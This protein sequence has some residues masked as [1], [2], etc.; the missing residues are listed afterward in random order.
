M[1]S[2]VSCFIEVNDMSKQEM[3]Y[4]QNLQ[5][6]LQLIENAGFASI[7]EFSAKSQIPMLQIYRLLQGL[8]PKI[9]VEIFLKLSEFLKISPGQLAEIF[10]P[11]ASP[12][13]I[14]RENK[15]D[16]I[17]DLREDFKK[18]YHLLQQEMDNIKQEVQ[19][20]AFY[21]L[22]SLL[23][24]LPTVTAAIQQ[25]PD[26]PSVKLLP[27]FRPV[28]QLLRE[29]NIEPIGTVGAKAVYDP[30]YHEILE[31]TAQEGDLVTV[32]YVGYKQGESVLYKTK[33]SQIFHEV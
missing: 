22:E 7:E 31:G 13:T 18:E 14:E 20:S 10:F 33:I 4:G 27:L 6:I 29:W 3:I 32:R 16:Q 12:P 24:Q 21:S 26:F 2:I 28:N 19:R 5:N 30:P 8:L 15:Q 1:E 17:N 11:Q 23:L 9:N 25:N